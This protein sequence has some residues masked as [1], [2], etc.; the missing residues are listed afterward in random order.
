LEDKLNEQKIKES[1]IP[2]NF[3]DKIQ[4]KELVNK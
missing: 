3:I 2:D 4:K 1:A